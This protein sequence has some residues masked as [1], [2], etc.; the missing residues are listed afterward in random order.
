MMKV[1]EYLDG[2]A[3]VYTTD[4]TACLGDVADGF[5]WVHFHLRDSL[6]VLAEDD[7]LPATVRDALLAME[8]RPRCDRL[9]G[10]VLLNLRA[11]MPQEELD[12]HEGDL[13]VSIRL[14]GIPNRL[15]SVSFRPSTVIQ[16]VIE[17]FS[18]GQIVDCGDA[19]MAILGETT[20]QLDTRV[21]DLGDHLDDLESNI[22]THADFED[23]RKTTRL[24]SKAISLRRFIA[25]ER[26][27]LD[28]L[29]ALNLEWFDA[30]ER[31]RL[32]E[33][34][35]RFYRMGEELESVRERA[36]VVHDEITDLRAERID[37]RSLQLAIVALIFLPLTF[38]TGLLGMNVK[39]IPSADDPNA[40]WWVTGLCALIAVAIAL[41][42]VWRGW[43]RR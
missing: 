43:S 25:P 38:V 13:L 6:N 30:D 5:R 16:P 4:D 23:R 32:R 33:A 1:M 22:S 2:Q 42:F 7:R 41:W 8:T 20:E 9:A 15:I 10:G 34:T 21:A 27:A 19:I 35:D 37:A 26:Q 14:W 28:T 29:Q 18:N 40:F 17:R 12:K 11:P 24:R 3:R 39:G 31:A 36:A